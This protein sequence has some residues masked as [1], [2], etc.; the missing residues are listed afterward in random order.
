H[1][2]D[3]VIPGEHPAGLQH[4]IPRL[5][6]PGPQLRERADGSAADGASAAVRLKITGTSRTGWHGQIRPKRARPIRV[7]LPMAAPVLELDKTARPTA[8]IFRPARAP[9]RRNLGDR[10]QTKTKR[11]PHPI[12]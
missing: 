5:V 10:A 1:L 3:A 12:Q 8:S 2:A 6:W 9:L 4:G 7:G 11:S